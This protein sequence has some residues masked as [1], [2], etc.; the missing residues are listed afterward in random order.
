VQNLG[1]KI[2]ATSCLPLR[3]DGNR[4]PGLAVKQELCQ[5]VKCR[6]D[7]YNLDEIIG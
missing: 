7:A 6:L 5:E 4:F 3:I 2:C 1:S